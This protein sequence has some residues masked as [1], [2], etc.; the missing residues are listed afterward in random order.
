[1]EETRQLGL[2]V[3]CKAYYRSKTILQ[4]DQVLWSFR[5]LAVAAL[6]ILV[7]ASAQNA[8][9]ATEL[10]YDDFTGGS[11]GISGPYDAVRFTLTDFGLTSACLLAARLWLWLPDEPALTP[12]RVHVLGSDGQTSLITPFDFTGPSNEDWNDAYLPGGGVIVTGEFWIALYFYDD[13]DS[14]VHGTDTNP[15]LGGHSY[16]GEPGSWIQ[17]NL[18][19]SAIRAMVQEGPCPQTS[20]PVGGFVE[21]VNK[22]AV[23]APYLA[24]FGVIGAVAVFFWKR[25]DN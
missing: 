17:D 23:F 20:A 25:P 14:P 2:T 7:L 10:K 12:L 9:A 24:L 4:K 1:M 11:G 19:D 6:V 3:S 22:L 13:P 21:P 15:P 16:S 5:L 18:R 8:F